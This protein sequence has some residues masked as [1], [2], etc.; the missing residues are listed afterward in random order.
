MTVKVAP[1]TTSAKEAIFAA[2]DAAVHA[3]FG[4]IPGAFSS[5]LTTIRAL[6]NPEDSL[7]QRA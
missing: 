2:T 5:V 1:G 4:D 7:D 3:I 6:G